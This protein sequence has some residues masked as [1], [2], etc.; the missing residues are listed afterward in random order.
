MSRKIG[1]WIDH[2]KAVIVSVLGRSGRHPDAGIRCRGAPRYSRQEGAGGGE[3]LRKRHG[4]ELD[5]SCDDIIGQLGKPEALLI[6]G[7]GEA[8][9][10]F[11]E[12][13][14]SLQGVVRDALSIG[15]EHGQADGSAD[16]AKVKEH[17][18]IAR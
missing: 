3:K 2:K 9:L 18:G 1:I 8:K 14:R 10:E 6:F 5:R 17:Y 12:R 11:K 13:L 16:V 15:R 4:Q 7:P